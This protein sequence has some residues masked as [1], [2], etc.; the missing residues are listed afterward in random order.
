MEGAEFV[1]TNDGLFKRR[2]Y[3]TVWPEPPSLSFLFD[4]SDEDEEKIEKA[5]DEKLDQADALREIRSWKEDVKPTPKKVED[6]PSTTSSQMFQSE[7][8]A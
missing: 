2:C 8:R 4:L 1:V 7:I 6:N 5:E 3:R